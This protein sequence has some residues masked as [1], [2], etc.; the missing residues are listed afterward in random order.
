MYVYKFYYGFHA[1]FPNLGSHNNVVKWKTFF[2][3][4][5]VSEEQ[6]MFK[7]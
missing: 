5:L 6:A 1:F 7:T 3:F 2:F 4:W